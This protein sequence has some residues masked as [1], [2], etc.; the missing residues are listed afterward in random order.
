M[1]PVVQ[2]LDVHHAYDRQPILRGVSFELEPGAI[3][4]LLGPSGCG[5]TTVLRC[6]AG[7]EPVTDGEI[8]LSGAVV[9]C[10]G[11]TVPTERR[12][13]GIVFQDYA[14]FPHLTVARNV[15]FGLR[16]LG[17]AQ[18]RA[19]VSEL[20]AI[21]S[22]ERYAGHYPHQLSGGQQQRVALARALAPRPDL[23]LLD[24]PFSNLD[25]EL[26]ERLSV[27]VRD[28]LK[29]Q[30]L[31]AILVTHDQHEAFNIA[32]QV[33]I[34][35]GGTIVQWAAPYHL[36]HEP[37][38][39]FVADFI[40]QGVF[41]PGTV[42]EGGRIELELG[43]LNAGSAGRWASGTAVEVLLRPDDI[44]H[45]DR[46]TLQAQVLHKAFRGAEFLYTLQLPG[47]SRLLSL[48]PSH[49][50]HGIGEKIGIRLEVD[51]VVAFPRGRGT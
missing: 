40:G 6:I 11:M 9:S 21:T 38:N 43:V 28:I 51:H 2:L 35:N 39:R 3:G 12:H 41:L 25:V 1:S 26:R 19:R 50:D 49:H 27:E 13:I 31:T 17:S 24:E 5:K 33:G 32:D 10:K 29:H 14:L 37:A 42:R 45:D 44:L 7:F 18:R 30:Q 47:G 20:L 8:R 48:V 36:Y 34:V 4:C 46:S 15:A 16:T 22:L 23:L